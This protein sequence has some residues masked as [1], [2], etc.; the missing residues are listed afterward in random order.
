LVRPAAGTLISVL[1]VALIAAPVRTSVVDRCA[2]EDR[3]AV[4]DRS[5]AAAR[6]EE[7]RHAAPVRIAA[8]PSEVAQTVVIPRGVRVVTQNAA[9]D[10]SV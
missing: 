10:R 3:F 9:G 6:F 4:E 8:V 5:V 1:T 7:S 2:V